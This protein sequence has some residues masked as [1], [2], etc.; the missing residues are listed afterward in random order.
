[1]GAR[2]LELLQAGPSRTRRER[3][4]KERPVPKDRPFCYCNA[5]DLLLG[6]SSGRRRGRSS[7]SSRIGRLGRVSSRGRRSSSRLGSFFLLAGGDG[8]QRQESRKQ[9][10]VLFHGIG[11]LLAWSGIPGCRL[12]LFQG[13][14]TSRTH[15]LRKTAKC[16]IAVIVHQDSSF[17]LNGACR[18]TDGD[19]AGR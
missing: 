14:F 18:D 11:F 17:R 13:E 16:S 9:N 8:R 15:I 6:R 19:Q 7:R 5:N 1:M 4:K 12:A 3:A 2:K 10:R